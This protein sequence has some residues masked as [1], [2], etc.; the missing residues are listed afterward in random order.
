MGP[1]GRQKKAVQKDFDFKKIFHDPYG[2]RSSRNQMK[3][4]TGRNKKCIGKETGKHSSIHGQE[5]SV[6]KL[7]PIIYIM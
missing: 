2:P 6:K 1:H 7:R 4:D 5:F 3:K